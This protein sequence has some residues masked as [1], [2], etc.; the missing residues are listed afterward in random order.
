MI[1]DKSKTNHKMGGTIGCC[2]IVFEDR[3]SNFEISM[4]TLVGYIGVQMKHCYQLIVSR[5]TWGIRIHW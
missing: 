1:S 3:G 4:L 2:P 5:R